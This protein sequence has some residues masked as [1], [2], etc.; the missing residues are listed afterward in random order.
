MKKL[1]FIIMLLAVS[2]NAFA[3]TGGVITAEGATNDLV[4]VT[5][6]TAPTEID[7]MYVMY[8]PATASTDSV[9]YAVTD[10]TA[11]SA[12]ISGLSER[13]GIIVFLLTRNGDGA[14]AISNKITTNTYKTQVQPEDVNYE[15]G[16]LHRTLQT[17]ESWPFLGDYFRKDTIFTLSGIGDTDK[18]LIFRNGEYT[19]LDI[20][21]SQAGDSCAA[22]AYIRA[23]G[24]SVSGIDTSYFAGAVV[25]SLQLGEAGTPAQGL[26]TKSLKALSVHR[27]WQ[28]DLLTH[29]GNGKDAAYILK[30]END[31]SPT[32]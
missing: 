1:L 23:I 10:S 30:L 3:V 29:T 9:F 28:I 31:G 16:F 15:G 2:S 25:D 17:D 6:T 24:M 14:T 32:R 19:G 8:F 21:G 12:L 27:F 13:Q 4:K 5:I 18:S 26:V 22:T 11:T 20:I 7:T